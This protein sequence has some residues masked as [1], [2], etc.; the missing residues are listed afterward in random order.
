MRWVGWKGACI[1]PNLSKNDAK[2]VETVLVSAE[3][4]GR[5]VQVFIRYDGVGAPE[6]RNKASYRQALPR[7]QSYGVG[8]LV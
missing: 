6:A 2:Q 8:M 5:F 3:D 1:H 7:M 4:F